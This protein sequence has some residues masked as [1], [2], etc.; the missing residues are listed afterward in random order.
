MKIYKSYYV[1]RRKNANKFFLMS[2][3]AFS[4]KK[5]TVVSLETPHPAW[6]IVATSYLGL[7]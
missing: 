3:S 7:I 4:T 6:D 2:S 1:V 5:F